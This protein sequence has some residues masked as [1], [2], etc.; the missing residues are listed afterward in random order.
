MPDPY[1]TTVGTQAG[2]W[3]ATEAL[4]TANYKF[5][6]NRQR[7][8]NVVELGKRGKVVRVIAYNVSITRAKELC[9]GERFKIVRGSV[10]LNGTGRK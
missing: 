6:D 8:Y 3:R 9:K 1:W 2:R 5:E 4:K 7:I 10:S